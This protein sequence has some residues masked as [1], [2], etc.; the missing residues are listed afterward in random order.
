MKRVQRLLKL[1]ILF[2][3]SLGPHL[4]RPHMKFKIYPLCTTQPDSSDVIYKKLTS[5]SISSSLVRSPSTQ[6]CRKLKISRISQMLGCQM[7]N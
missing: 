7:K 3:H 6:K 1:F 5:V 2:S 4:K